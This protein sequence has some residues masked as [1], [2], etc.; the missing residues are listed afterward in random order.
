MSS[1][2]SL[3]SKFLIYSSMYCMYIVLTFISQRPVICKLEWSTLTIHRKTRLSGCFLIQFKTMD[4][5]QSETQTYMKHII[6][7]S[8]RNSIQVNFLWTTFNLLFKRPFS[9]KPFFL[10]KNRYKTMN[11]SLRFLFG[12]LHKKV[13]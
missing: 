1:K 6:H 9:L 2:N 7:K 3:K 8:A 10:F 11:P 5:G 13:F 4:I 12:Y